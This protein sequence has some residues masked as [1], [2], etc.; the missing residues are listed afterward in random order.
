MGERGRGDRDGMPMRGGVSRRAFLSGAGAL[1]L[2]LMAVLAGCGQEGGSGAASGSGSDSG[3]GDKT[4]AMVLSGPV[5]DGGFNSTCYDAMKQ[6]AQELGWKSEYT[7]NVSQS[8]YVTAAQGYVD[9]GATLVIMAGSEFNDAAKQV[10]GDN[11]DTKFAVMSSSVQGPNLEGITADNQQVGRI[12][13]VVAATFTKT[14]SVAYVGGMEIDST[15]TQMAGYEEAVKK[16]KPEASVSKVFVGS[17]TDVAKGKDAGTTFFGE[18]NADF[19]FGDGDAEENGAIQAMKDAVK[20]D[21]KPRA[22][23][24]NPD[25]LG[26][27]DSDVYASSV[28]TDYPLMVKDVMKEVEDG[29]FGGKVFKGDLSNGVLRLGKFSNKLLT[30]EQQKAIQDEVAKI[31][32]GSF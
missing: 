10:S 11:P 4:V 8:D 31:R 5:N 16:L 7:E 6:A 20:K 13:G 12:A 2:G 24:G 9:Q 18:K 19:L 30:V 1:G 17:F 29:K 23:M 26:G 28:V 21:S 27:A 25:D 32:D 15:R 3:S 14:G 22:V